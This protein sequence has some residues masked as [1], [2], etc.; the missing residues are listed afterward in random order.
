GIDME[1]AVERLTLSTKAAPVAF[2]DALPL[3][4]EGA[5]RAERDPVMPR[6]A[7][8]SNGFQLQTAT[9]WLIDPE[10]AGRSTEFASALADHSGLAPAAQRITGDYSTVR[11]PPGR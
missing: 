1:R 10:I 5:G 9:P 6:L 3:E 4:S 11:S 8:S 7:G 2:I